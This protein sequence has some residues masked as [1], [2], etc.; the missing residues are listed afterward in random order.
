MKTL[1]LS[2]TLLF[3]LAGCAASSGAS[4][5]DQ[6]SHNLNEIYQSTEIYK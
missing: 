6:S 1:L 3:A 4:S 2:L 5:Y